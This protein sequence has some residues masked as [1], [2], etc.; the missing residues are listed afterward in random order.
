[1]AGYS[2]DTQKYNILKSLAWDYHVHGDRLFEVLIGLR[3]K[4]GPFDQE[5][6]FIRVIERL[7]WHDVLKIMGRE[8]VK[9]LLTPECIAK[10][11]FPEQRQRYE[12]IRKILHGEP[13]SLSGWDPRHRETYKRSILSNRWH[14]SKPAL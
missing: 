6:I 14:R 12:R 13:L 3:R 10:L 8:K 1:M 9:Q 2:T 5:K 7:P 4:E 11:R